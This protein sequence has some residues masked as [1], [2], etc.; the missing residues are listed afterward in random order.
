M[1]VLIAIKIGNDGKRM[2][3]NS[4]IFFKL[5]YQ[6]PNSRIILSLHLQKISSCSL[7]TPG[8]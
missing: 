2:I 8:F 1:N 3:G 7:L 5:N 6:L 4:K